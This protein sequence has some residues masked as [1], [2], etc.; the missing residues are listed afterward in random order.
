MVLKW[1]A[2]FSLFPSR[3][4]QESIRVTS[5]LASFSVLDQLMLTFPAMM[6]ESYLGSGLQEYNPR[7]SPKRRGI[8][9]IHQV[10]F[11]V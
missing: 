8:F 3:S 5:P 7:L 9:G 10:G 2:A 11:M 6:A 4:I 1:N